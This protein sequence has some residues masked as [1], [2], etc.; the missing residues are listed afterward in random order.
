MTTDKRKAR[1]RKEGHELREQWSGGQVIGIG[2]R[3]CD[4]HFPKTREW[5]RRRTAYWKARRLAAVEH[6]LDQW[7]QSYVLAERI[8]A[9][10]RAI[11]ESS[12]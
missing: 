12:P 2:C 3:R 9:V 6:A 10:N 7:R 11:E 8:V 1:C 4:E 5:C